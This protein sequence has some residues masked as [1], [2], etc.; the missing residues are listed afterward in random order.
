[1]V[2]PRG[3]CV[4]RTSPWCCCRKP[5]QSPG[6]ATFEL[7]ILGHYFASEPVSSPA[8][9]MEVLGQILDRFL[10]FPLVWQTMCGMPGTA[11][12]MVGPPLTVIS[13][14]PGWGSAFAGVVGGFSST[15]CP[16]RSSTST[17]VTCV[18]ACTRHV[19][20]KRSLFSLRL[21]GWCGE[22]NSP[23]WEGRKREGGGKSSWGLSTEVR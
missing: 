1:M 8:H 3:L 10:L 22:R 18:G 2:W 13:E 9:Q 19:P 7:C 21:C 20:Q 11:Q 14:A 16:W 17:P 12:H 5:G 6:F 15:D 4:L 23:F